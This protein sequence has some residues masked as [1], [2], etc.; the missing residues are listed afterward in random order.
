M[1]LDSTSSTQWGWDEILGFLLTVSDEKMFNE[2]EIK[3]IDGAKK[4]YETSKTLTEKQKY[5][6]TNMLYRVWGE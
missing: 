1:N 5:K 4:Q 3:F 6:I 2:W